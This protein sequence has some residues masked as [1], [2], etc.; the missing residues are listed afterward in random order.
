MIFK[1]AKNRGDAYVARRQISN[2][3]GATFRAIAMPFLLIIALGGCTPKDQG[4]FS[5]HFVWEG[6]T[7]SFETGAYFFARI[8]ERSDGV[9]TAGRILGTNAGEL[10]TSGMTLNITDIPNGEN[11]VVVAELREGSSADAQVLYYGLSEAF[12]LK[13][14]ETTSVEVFMQMQAVPGAGEDPVG[15][16]LTIDGKALPALVADAMVEL[17]L[18][19]DTGI[20][21]RLSNVVSF[22]EHASEVIELNRELN[23][24]DSDDSP[25]TVEWDLNMGYPDCL[26]G[27]TCARRVYARFIDAQGYE[28]PTV[29]GDATIDL[30]DPSLVTD[31]T[32]VVPASAN[33][34]AIVLI[35]IVT[36]KL[37]DGPPLLGAPMDTAFEVI[38]PSGDLPSATWI[39]QAQGPAKDYWSDSDYTITATLKDLVGH[40]V[41]GVAVGNFE[42]DSTAPGLIEDAIITPDQVRLGQTYT[43]EFTVNEDLPEPPDVHVRVAGIDMDL[44]TPNASNPRSFSCEHTPLAIEGNGTKQ[45]TITLSDLAGNRASLDGGVVSYDMFAPVVVSETLLRSPSFA[46]ADLGTTVLFTPVDPTHPNSPVEAQ[47]YIYADETLAGA[48][49]LRTDPVLLDFVATPGESDN[50]IIF[51][52]TIN[53]TDAEGEYHFWVTWSDEVG[54]SVEVAIQTTLTIDKTPPELVIAQEQITYLRSPWGNAASEAVGDFVTPAGPYYALAP[55][56]PLS[57][58]TTLLGSTFTLKEDGPPVELRFWADTQQSLLLGSMKPTIDPEKGPE[59]E[60]RWSWP[61]LQLSNVDTPAVYVTALDA[62][63]NESQPLRIENG[64]WVATPNPPGFGESPHR[65]EATTYV[66]PTLTQNP[67]IT[68]KAEPDAEGIEGTSELIRAENAWREQKQDAL[69]PEARYGHT[70]VWNSARGVAI[71]F[72]GTYDSYSRYQDTWEW[73]GTSWTDVTP[74][75]TK[76]SARGFH[77]MVYDSARD[78][79]IVFGGEDSSGKVQDIWEWNGTSW[80]DV[81]PTGELP[82][83]RYNHAMA[84]DSARGVTVLFGGSDG[85]NKTQ[86]T[87]EWNGT[88][89]TD[90]T[91]TG[92]LPSARQNHAMAYNSSRGTVILFGG[93]G[94]SEHKTQDTWEWDGTSWTDISPTDTKPSP[95]YAHSIVWDDAREVIVLFGGFEGSTFPEETWEWDGSSWTDVT[96]A[97]AKPGPRWFHTMVYDSTNEE[98]V[99]VGGAHFVE[100]TPDAWKW[101]GRRWADIT[102]TGEKPSARSNHAMVYDSAREVVVLFG[103]R[104]NAENITQDTWEWNGTL[105][106]DVSPAEAKPGPIWC[107]AMAY[108]SARGVTVLFG[109]E[110]SSGVKLDGVWEWD[111]VSWELRTPDDPEGDGNPTA[112]YEHAMAYDSARGVIILFGGSDGSIKSQDA[113]EWNG[114]SWAD[115]TPA[116]LK[117][118]ARSSHT[119]AHDNARGV[120]VLFGGA[121]GS[122]NGSQDTWEWDGENWTNVTP[123]GAKPDIRLNHTMIYDSAR[124][125]MVLFGGCNFPDHHQDI[126]EWDGAVWTNITP[127]GIKPIA[128]YNHAMAWDNI[129]DT[130]VV[131]GGGDDGDDRE[132]TWELHRNAEAAIIF[133]V[134][135]ANAGIT[136]N[137]VTDVHI[138][139]R[140]G[141]E[142]TSGAGATLYGWSNGISIDASQAGNPGEW[143]QLKTNDVG[144]NT[145]RPYLPDPTSEST[146]LMEWTSA[147]EGESRCYVF[148]S[149][150][151]IQCRPL[152]SPKLGDARSAVAMD[153]IEARVRYTLPAICG[154][155]GLE[156]DEACDDGNTTDGDGCSAACWVE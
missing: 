117:P 90:V 128:R 120:T 101:N 61:R 124:S 89:W 70:M 67:F 14:G 112:R 24:A 81:T 88:D 91:P 19:T 18:L 111:G 56:E 137:D 122:T 11:R 4:E 65:L 110:D 98:V 57:D 82:S 77:T 64:E 8:E 44:C 27:E 131:F 26:A 151:Y 5:I 119:L 21:V 108:D 85:S 53:D 134:E 113:W 42:V 78:V 107:H 75:G 142:T 126:W 12:E 144:L 152:P 39:F 149:G 54:N 79:V 86:D 130:A 147:S 123:A 145:E 30:L 46:A 37:L 150:L 106:T 35:T 31:A 6:G 99:I 97:G 136:H 20:K 96:P 138:R 52:R 154:N 17:K 118:S 7:P 135:M 28:S 22:P 95:R 132:D 76:P 143:W 45:I 2:G 93:R 116:G 87:W 62:A 94:A 127:A 83:A 103:G 139:A 47:L 71:L 100:K 104:D 38:F 41:T 153:Y 69:F 155:G 115:V 1:T 43:V 66:E 68:S 114:T 148:K 48:P 15:E 34:D 49:L 129:R 50:S 51:K 59:D 105:W 33:G 29:Y 63:A 133:S 92:E 72:G 141:G 73:D 55:A 60:A 125:V 36:N 74:T 109:G 25:V 146:A 102:P 80:A 32:S 121:A 140:C 84:Y 13:A 9:Q 10:F 3:W 58:T 23:R 16:I 40:E 156:A